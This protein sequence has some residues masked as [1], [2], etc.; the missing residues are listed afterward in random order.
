MAIV[1][2][3]SRAWFRRLAVTATAAVVLPGL[4]G[5]TTGSSTAAAFSSPGL[6]IEYLEVPSQSMGRDIRGEFMSGG[7]NAH[8]VYLLDSMEAGD[9][10]NGWVINTQ[11]F[12]WYN[13]SGLSLVLPVGGKSSFYSDWYGPAVGNGGTY[14]YK[15]EP[16]S[17]GNCPRGLRPTGEFRRSATPSSGS[18]WAGRLRWCWPPITRIGSTTPDR[19]RA[20]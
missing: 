9:D 20:S 13:G 19:C 6:P 14:T 3:M 18:Q 10:F 5:V 11:A 12:D 1:A 4:V 16:S 2:E 7:P 15:W 17:L 8:V